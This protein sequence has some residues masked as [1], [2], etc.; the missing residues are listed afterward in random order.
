MSAL[1]TLRALPL[2]RLSGLL[3]RGYRDANVNLR[4]GDMSRSLSSRRRSEPW[5]SGRGSIGR[6]GSPRLPRSEG[7]CTRSDVRLLL[8]ELF[9]YEG[10]ARRFFQFDV[11][12]NL[13]SFRIV[14]NHSCGHDRDRKIASCA[15]YYEFDV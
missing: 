2:S 6:E 4:S 1:R 3:R 5:V 12:A 10:A 9:R 13:S 8:A 11:A 15:F 14:K 7:E